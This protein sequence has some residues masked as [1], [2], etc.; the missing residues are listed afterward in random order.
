LVPPKVTLVATE[1]PL[2]VGALLVD[3]VEQ[4][5]PQVIPVMKLWKPSCLSCQEKAVERTERD[6]FF[7]RDLLGHSAQS[8]TSQS[9]STPKETL[10][11]SL[12]GRRIS[13]LPLGNPLRHRFVE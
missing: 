6:V 12:T 2:Q 8:L 3:Q 4:N 11:Q 13:C 7:V 9:D 10:P 1:I 5:L